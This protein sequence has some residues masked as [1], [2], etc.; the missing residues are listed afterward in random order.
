MATVYRKKY[1]DDVMA[2]FSEMR[3]NKK[4]NIVGAPSFVSFADSIGVPISQIEKWRREHPDFE[5]A[6]EDAE[7]LLRQLLMDAALSGS[8]NVSAAKFILSSDFGMGRT[9]L[10]EKADTSNG[11]SD[12]DRALMENLAKR[13]GLDGYH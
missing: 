6:C 4:G 12:A 8:V 13:L 2:H 11:I 10:P 5:K 9:S 3:R 7:A 1:C